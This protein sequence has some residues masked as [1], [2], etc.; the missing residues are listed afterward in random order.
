MRTFFLILGLILTSLLGI[1]LWNTYRFD[2]KQVKDVPPAEAVAVS[3]SVIQHLSQAIQFR[4]VS[5]QDA[6]LTD[7]TQFEKFISYL[8]TTFP[9]VHARLK[10]EKINQYALLFEW[11]GSDTSL[12]PILMMGHYDVVPVIQG[13]ERMWKKAP[14][15]GIIED[16]FVYGRGTLDDKSTVMG[17]LE[18]AEL[19]LKQN[20]QPKRTLYFSFGHD[21][22][23]SGL[24]GG[25]A[26]AQT[27]EKRGVQLEMV[28]DEGGTIKTDGVAGLNQSVA[29]IGI[30][31]KGYTSVEIT[32]RGEGGHSS[33]PP[34]NTSIGLLATALDKLQQNPFKS[35]LGGTVGEMLRYLGPEMPFAQ[36]MAIANQWLLEPILIQSFGATN[37]GAA[38]TQTTIAPTILKAGIKDNVLPIDATAIVNFRILPGDSVQGVINHI[39]KVIDNQEIE[40]KSLEVFDTEPSPVSSPETETFQI[41]HRTIKSCYPEVLVSPYLVLGAT[42]ARYYRKLSENVYR[43]TPYQLD[44][45][46][47]KRPHGTNE[48]IQIDTYKAMIQFY[49]TLF[50]NTTM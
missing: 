35:S 11:K 20:Y 2:S 31:E 26:L 3:D 14:F 47:L 49:V 1:L 39:K 23:V 48:R 41:L 45:E 37:S 12:K 42:D 8:E 7:T 36:K 18:A 25:Q 44:E 50:K 32:A 43:F 28:I 29:L 4:T 27:L 13:T 5:Y 46:D 15:A 6:E 21:E 9:L 17:L 40:V 30:A 22:E 16:G 19:L 10:R 24:R 33:M 38:S 34:K